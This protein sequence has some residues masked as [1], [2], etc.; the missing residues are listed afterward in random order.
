MDSGK[1]LWS[2]ERS[3][4]GKKTPV[5]GPTAL[6]GL[7]P[8]RYVKKQ[9]KKQYESLLFAVAYFKGSK[10]TNFISVELI[11][12]THISNMNQCHVL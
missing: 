7:V 4:N 3:R 9:K 11:F 10:I 1:H 5:Y 12:L 6:M 8:L 2:N